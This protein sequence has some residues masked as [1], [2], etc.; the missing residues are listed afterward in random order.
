MKI[1][2]INITTITGRDPGISI[3][4]TNDI[5]VGLIIGNNGTITALGQIALI[6]ES[7]KKIKFFYFFLCNLRNE[8]IKLIKK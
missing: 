3:K 6:N 7:S 5:E 1:N 2:L 8:F 4:I